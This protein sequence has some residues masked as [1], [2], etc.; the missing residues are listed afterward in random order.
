MDE[1]VMEN[2][3]LC[4]GDATDEEVMAAAKPA[5][6]EEFIQRLTRGYQK[7]IGAT[8]RALPGGESQRISNATSMRQH[9]HTDMREEA[10]TSRHSESETMVQNA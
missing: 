10:T 1:T 7:N 9:D 4:R 5:Q 3:R 8:G 6:C 2:I